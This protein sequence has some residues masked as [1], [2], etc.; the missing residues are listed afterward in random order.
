MPLHVVT[1]FLSK[2]QR[3]ACGP[4]E[5]PYWLFRDFAHNLVP[6]VTSVF[7]SSLRQHKVPS[8]WKMADIKPLS[9]ESPLTSC[10]QHR[11]IS[12]TAVIMRLFESLVYRFELSSI[13]KH[14]IDLDQ[15]AYRDGHNSTMALI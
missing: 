1:Q 4:D 5:L 6:A 9:K 13:C 7:N 15:F 8:S 12:F 10:I 14:Y 3:T 2:L 11:P